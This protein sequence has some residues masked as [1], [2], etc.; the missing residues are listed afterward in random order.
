MSVTIITTM[1]PDDDA[2]YLGTFV[3]D[4]VEF[5]GND[6]D[7]VYPGNKNRGS[8]LRFYLAIYKN[9]VSR[10][11]SSDTIVIHYPLFFLPLVALAKIL[12]KDI[13]LVYHG[14]EFMDRPGR[15]ANLRA[16]RRL[17]FRVNN[18]LADRI[19]V[20]SK[21]TASTYFANWKNKLSIWY[22]GGI[23]IGR[24]ENTGAKRQYDF[25][26]F[27]RMDYEKGYDCYIESIESLSAR[28]GR[29]DEVNCLSVC[30]E[31]SVL[32][33]EKTRGMTISHSPP[34]TNIEVLERLRLCTFVV[35]PSRVESLCLLALEAAEAGSI[36]IARRIPAIEETLGDLAIFFDDDHELSGVLENALSMPQERRAGIIRGLKHQV[37]QFD[38]RI[39]Q[40]KFQ[41][42]R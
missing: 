10:M 3:R 38:R 15:R 21:F 8:K 39:L 5:F 27:G 13:V 7:V 42:V 26:Y 33:S 17:I 37:K 19:F 18:A 30:R 23:K 25:G 9:A 20:P 40:E 6:S 31:N 2:P 11:F 35:I 14:G 41:L 16:F 29:N 34:A 4:T 1:Y 36:I 12:R 24:A 28:I 22:S 32:R